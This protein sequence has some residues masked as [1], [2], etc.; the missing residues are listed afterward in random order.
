VAP[1]GP[2]FRQVEVYS[3]GRVLVEPVDHLAVVI[4]GLFSD[5][6]ARHGLV[7]RRVGQE[8]TQ[9][10]VVGLAELVLNDHHVALIPQE[11][12]HDVA[13]EVTRPAFPTGLLDLHA[14]VLRQQRDAIGCHEPI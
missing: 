4:C 8:L 11:L 1:Q 14:Q 2:E 7:D 6:Y 3:G 5:P 9:M 13:G 12:R 10:I